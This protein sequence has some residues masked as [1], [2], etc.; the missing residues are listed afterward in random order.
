MSEILAFEIRGRFTD[1]VVGMDGAELTRGAAD[2]RGWTNN[3]IVDRALDL[4]AALLA[5]QSDTRGILYW[6]VGEGEEEWDA[7]PPDTDPQTTRLVHEIYRKP[8]DPT[9]DLRYDPT[10]RTISL[11]VTFRPDEAAGMLREFGI[12]GGDATE[13]AASGYLI[14][15]KIHALIDKTLPRALERHLEF[16]IGPAPNVVVPNLVSRTIDA[17]QNALDPL[18]LAV[19]KITRVES[20]DA[21]DTILAQFPGAGARAAIGIGI[22]LTVASPPKVVVPDLT[23]LTRARAA[24]VLASIGLVLDELPL[25]EPSDDEPGTIVNQTPRAGTRLTLG[26]SVIV[27]EAVVRTVVVPDVTGMELSAA[28]TELARA[29]LELTNEPA[30]EE[31]AE[32]T[33]GLILAQTPAAGETVEVDSIVQVTLSAPPTVGVPNLDGLDPDAAGKTL[34]E[35]GLALGG[36]TQEGSDKPDGLVFRQSPGAGLRVPSG[37]TVDIVLAIPLPLVAPSV[38]GLTLEQA[39]RALEEVGLVL[40]DKPTRRTSNL[41]TNTIIEQD[42]AAGA[43]TGKG[44]T[45]RVVLADAVMLLMPNLISK[46]LDEA[47]ELVKGASLKLGAPKEVDEPDVKAWTVLEQSPAAGTRIAEGTEVTLT[48]S[49]PRVNVPNLANL[50]QAQ[51]LPILQEFD[52]ALD[53]EISQKETTNADLD[54]RVAEQTP[55]ANERV[56]PGSKVKIVLWQVQRVTVPNVVGMTQAEAAAAL[57]R[58]GL[59]TGADMLTKATDKRDDVGRVAAQFPKANE[60][61][62]RGQ[63]VQLTV[64]VAQLV[65]VPDIVG[66]KAETAR[67]VLARAGLE[68]SRSN[69]L[70]DNVQQQDLVLTQQPGA[71]EQV[72]PG[73][74]VFAAVGTVVTFPELRCRNREEAEA[75]LNEYLRKFGVDWDRAISVGFQPSFEEPNI[76]VG[77]TPAMG[78]LI[79]GQLGNVG[80]TV[81]RAPLPDVRFLPFER[82]IDVLKRWSDANGGVLSDFRTREVPS[83]REPGTIMAQKPEAFSADYPERGLVMDFMVAAPRSTRLAGFPDIMGLELT[84]AAKRVTTY[85]RSIPSIRLTSRLIDAPSER[86]ENTVLEQDPAPGGTPTGGTRIG[87]TVTLVLARGLFPDVLCQNL[88]RAQSM[89]KEATAGRTVNFTV[90]KQSSGLD[91]GTVLSQTPPPLAPIPAVENIIEVVLVV[92]T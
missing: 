41:P 92:A 30:A 53:T 76:V 74:T 16:T 49:A 4:L 34:A 61:V 45:V 57:K 19:G 62:L 39:Q 88:D 79:V 35:V 25:T 60:R 8:L 90:E 78:S 89:I 66:T 63:P 77:Q 70:I 14:N 17:A 82:G 86:P 37:S 44:A 67:Q 11:K 56:A 52:L 5:G 80:V 58:A 48:V 12:F 38:L 40:G 18:E 72:A 42:P 68:L 73:S 22:D 75:F 69:Q 23:G 9:R 1:R 2:V 15:Y 59:V 54:G 7:L 43:P 21:V 91:A 29:G 24:E 85:A 28:R 31:N 81:R 3:L 84:E 32:V 87:G 65:A 20:I 71:G 6:A 50:T 10:T 83:D 55:A 33:P 51:A 13:Q 46:Q 47:R 36:L 27:T 26:G 64:W